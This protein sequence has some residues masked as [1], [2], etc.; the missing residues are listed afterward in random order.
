VAPLR[1]Q[2]P[3]ELFDWARLAA[4]GVGVWPEDPGPAGAAGTVDDAAAAPLLAAF[5]YGYVDEDFAAVVRAFQR[6]F[7]PAQVTGEVDG[8]TAARLRA[9][10]GRLDRKARNS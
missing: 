9:L 7:R 6:H 5:G 3:G 10:V 4:A 2:D 1:K 8:E